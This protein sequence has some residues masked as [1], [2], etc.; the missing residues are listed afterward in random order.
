M[1]QNLKVVLRSLQKIVLLFYLLVFGFSQANAQGPPPSERL[2]VLSSDWLVYDSRAALYVPFVADY[3]TQSKAIYLKINNKRL[4]PGYLCF[5]PKQKASLYIK[6]HFIRYCNAREWQNIRLDSL[7]ALEKDKSIELTLF[8]GDEPSGRIK[9]PTTYILAK[10]FR[11]SEAPVTTTPNTLVLNEQTEEEESI[12]K[13]VLNRA[14]EVDHYI[15]AFALVSLLIISS[16]LNKL[17]PVFSTLAMRQIVSALN[18][19]KSVTKRLDAALVFAYT[20]FYALLTALFLLTLQR[21]GAFFQKF[22]LSNTALSKL[23]MNSALIIAACCVGVLLKYLFIRFFAYLFFNRSQL[24]DLHFWEYIHIS[25]LFMNVAT[26][27]LFLY[28]TL[29][30]FL[31]AN[32]TNFILYVVGT[33]FVVRLIILG[34]RLIPDLK[35]HKLYLFSYL[36]STE[37]LPT[38]AVVGF[39]VI[40]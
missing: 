36:C 2:E 7:Y 33:L 18:A 40:V 10:P 21:Y 8:F 26:V 12:Y 39:L 1:F 38:L 13:K 29:V 5:K 27:C 23:F 32:T 22:P 9:A 31:P 30:R 25:L 3:H 35:G 34:Y 15:M 24:G 19:P 4:N 16:G 37:I 11:E 17:H 14:S 20:I 28:L 6:Q